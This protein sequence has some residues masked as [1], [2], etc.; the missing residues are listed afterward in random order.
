MI[1]GITLSIMSNLAFSQSKVTILTNKDVNNQR[2]DSMVLMEI[3]EN[4]EKKVLQVMPTSKSPLQELEE[5][6]NRWNVL[7]C[8]RDIFE[9][10]R[11][12]AMSKNGVII[13]ILNGHEYV[14]VGRDHFP[15]RQSAIKID[16]N[17]TVYGTEGVFKENTK[18]IKQMLKGKILHYRYYEF[19]KDYYIDKSISLDDF[20]Q[21]YE[22]LWQKYREIE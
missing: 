13:M 9:D 18:I 7:R 20:K 1:L 6:K 19:P 16:N 2:T 21:A 15:F 11:S 22:N 3:G 8:K 14:S 17:P 5:F 10:K 12:C 4:G